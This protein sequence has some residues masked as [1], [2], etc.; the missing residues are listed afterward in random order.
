MEIVKLRN[1][2][3]REQEI[4]RLTNH[5]TELAGHIKMHQTK[6]LRLRRMRDEVKAKIEQ[7]SG[8]QA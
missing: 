1:G 6:E 3:S 7:L 4:Q 8:K 2:N 5:D